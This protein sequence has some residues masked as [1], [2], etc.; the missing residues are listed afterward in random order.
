MG[1]KG[2]LTL[3]L[4]QRERG[5]GVGTGWVCRFGSGRGFLQTEVCAPMGE[6]LVGELEVLLVEVFFVVVLFAAEVL[7]LV[8]KLHA[9]L[10]DFL[11]EWLVGDA[12]EALEVGR[13]GLLWV[14]VG[15]EDAGGFLD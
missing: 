14:E 10:S 12:L 5:T 7:L 9:V 15:G 8:L 11:L 1:K 6:C 3:T 13:F 4:S 2:S